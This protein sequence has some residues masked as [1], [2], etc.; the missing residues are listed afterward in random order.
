MTADAAMNALRESAEVSDCYLDYDVDS[1]GN[2]RTGTVITPAFLHFRDEAVKF[3]EANHLEPKINGEPPEET[4][5]LGISREINQ[6]SNYYNGAAYTTSY[7]ISDVINLDRAEAYNRSLY[8]TYA[9]KVVKAEEA[10]LRARQ[11]DNTIHLFQSDDPEVYNELRRLA[12][13]GDLGEN[14]FSL[15]D[16]IYQMHGSADE[17][18]MALARAYIY[19]DIE[20]ANAAGLA[21]D[22]AD[23]INK[24]SHGGSDAGGAEGIEI[25][26]QELILF[27]ELTQKIA[28]DDPVKLQQLQVA[29]RDKNYPKGNLVPN[30]DKILEES[31]HI[32]T[33]T[34][35]FY[36]EG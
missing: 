15:S 36:A 12:Y 19:G 32:G 35:M 26:D 22:L 1:E 33:A 3:N 30:F 8:G 23:R 17:Q 31:A 9:P 27:R 29:I 20:I 10:V 11:S 21:L 34:P 28:Q 16:A 4:F 25:R 2:I 14:V 7:E 6:R 5:I 24:R 13:E 18:D